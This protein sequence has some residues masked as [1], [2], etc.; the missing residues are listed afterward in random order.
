MSKMIKHEREIKAAI[1]ATA[2]PEKYILVMYSD[3]TE[4]AFQITEKKMKRV[5][6]WDWMRT[7]KVKNV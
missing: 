5:K 6:V 3:F 4:A 1:Y 2:G 7:G